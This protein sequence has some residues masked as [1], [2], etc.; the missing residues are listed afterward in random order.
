VAHLL[1]RLSAS[2]GN[3]VW[4]RVAL[5]ACGAVALC[6]EA[7]GPVVDSA[8]QLGTEPT[9]GALALVV[10]DVPGGRRRTVCVALAPLYRNDETAAVA[11]VVVLRDH[12]CLAIHAP[13]GTV[14]LFFDGSSSPEVQP[15]AGSHALECPWCRQP[16]RPGELS[17]ACPECGVV[18]HQHASAGCWLAA[19]ACPRCGL[20][21]A[22]SDGPGWRPA[23]F[24]ST[25]VED[26]D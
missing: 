25:E 1:Q 20:P 17:V 12:D 16:V 9:T 14:R 13:A 5:P 22:R 24:P 4:Q 7:G 11:G 19:D 8:L 26:V 2:G 10:V 15:L 23:G 6:A 3:A 18:C 21:T